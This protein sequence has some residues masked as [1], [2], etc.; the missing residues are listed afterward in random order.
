M[1]G[2]VSKVQEDSN[3][4]LQTYTGEELTTVGQAMVEVNYEDQECELPIQIIKG[5]GPAL[6]CRK[7]DDLDDVLKTHR[8]VFKARCG[9]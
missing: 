8:E 4:R 7:T 5:N 9:I 2:Q 3:V 6:F 1:E